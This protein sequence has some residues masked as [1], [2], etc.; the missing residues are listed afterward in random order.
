MDRTLMTSPDIAG[1]SRTRGPVLSLDGLSVTA[2][3][4][5]GADLRIV[6]RVDLDL[7]VGER[8]ALVGESGSGKSVT[9]RAVL[10]LHGGLRIGGRVVLRGRDITGL[11]EREM[12]G[13]RGREIGMVFQNPMGALD[14]LLS[15]GAQVAAPLRLAGQSR[16]SARDRARALLCELGV[17]DAA[18]RM[19]AYPHEF[20]GGMRQRVVLAMALAGDPAVLLADEPTTALDV[21]AQEQVLATLDQVARERDLSVLFITHD[22]A[23]VAGFADRVA[24]MYA[25]RVV[26]T[27]P[28][29]AVFADPAH[30]YTRGLLRALPRVDRV[31]PELHGMAGTTPHPAARP[32]GCAFHPRCP[33]RMPR[34]EIELPALVGSPQAGTVACHLFSEH[35]GQ[36]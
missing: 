2:R 13:V 24:V 4:R 35:G 12:T 9:A 34:C 19:R 18:R 31:M 20:S 6:E 26:H 3:G 25:G 27:D 11:S 14:P 23:S 21:R 36:P 10:G 5:D 29:D 16:R 32:G 7:H 17:P 8:V 30:P 15:V 1:D 28:V 33:R 22:L